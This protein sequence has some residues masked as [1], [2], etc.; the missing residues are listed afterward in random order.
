MQEGANAIGPVRL[1][2]GARLSKALYTSKAASDV[3]CHPW[4]SFIEGLLCATLSGRHS[5]KSITLALQNSSLDE[6]YYTVNTFRKTD[7][8]SGV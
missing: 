3:A 1:A 6:Y 4:T 8:R 2:D 7:A 5:D